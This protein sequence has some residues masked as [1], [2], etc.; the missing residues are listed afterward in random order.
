MKIT[1]VFTK[2]GLISCIALLCWGCGKKDEK[3]VL[4]D[5]I[6]K[7]AA[8]EANDAVSPDDLAEMEMGTGG[9]SPLGLSPMALEPAASPPTGS[10]LIFLDPNNLKARLHLLRVAR[11]P[12]DALM[13]FYA[14]GCATIDS[15][16]CPK[17]GDINNTCTISLPFT[18]GCNTISIP[19]ISGSLNLTFSGGLS[20]TIE[21]NY[22]NTGFPKVTA[23]ATNFTV[24]ADDG[25]W[26]NYNGAVSRQITGIYGGLSPT[27]ASWI[28][29]VD[30]GAEDSAGASGTANGTRTVEVEFGKYFHASNVGTLTFTPPNSTNTTT[31]DVDIERIINKDKAALTKTIT[32]N[33]TV[34]TN[35]IKKTLTGNMTLSGELRGSSGELESITI[36][37]SLTRSG[38][39]GSITVKFDD[40]VIKLNCNHNPWGGTITVSNGEKTY[41]FDFRQD[42]GCNVDITK[43]DGS[44][45]VYNTC[46]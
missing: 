3:A 17:L 30:I 36:N 22:N 28:L 34:L 35:G 44:T 25:R 12:L 21:G 6:A 20:G 9:L 23:D 4:D 46:T 15:G 10:V 38:P 1:S 45:V 2:I 43:P 13:Y 33:D 41:T 18:T 31:I 32:I 7:S 24:T 42:C 14:T 37:G 16:P 39:K 29:S 40:V 11:A 27:G 5:D 19:T 26:I 8:I